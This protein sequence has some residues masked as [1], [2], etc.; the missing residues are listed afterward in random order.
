MGRKGLMKPR[1]AFDR[2]QSAVANLLR[3]MPPDRELLACVWV[4]PNFVAAP[5]VVK[6]AS[7]LLQKLF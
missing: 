4:F 7:I 6:A 3:V 1:V 2:S 5:L